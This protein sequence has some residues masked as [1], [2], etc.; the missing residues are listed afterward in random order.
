MKLLWRNPITLEYDQADVPSLRVTQN[1]LKIKASLLAELGHLID[2]VLVAWNSLCIRF[3]PTAVFDRD[4]VE[5]RVIDLSSQD[6]SLDFPA[7]KLWQFSVCYDPRLGVDIERLSLEKNLPIEALVQRHIEKTYSVYAC[8]FLPGFAYLGFTDQQLH[9]SRL[10]SPRKR[11]PAL[12]VAITQ[13]QTAIYPSASPGG[14]QIIGRLL[15]TPVNRSDLL[16]IG[17]GEQIQF[18]SISYEEWRSRSG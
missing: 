11:V 3:L 9:C 5:K 12:S 18:Q 15:D 2:E 16:K 1:L 6:N 13:N 14:W 10:A 8:G 7:S 4:Y 17:L